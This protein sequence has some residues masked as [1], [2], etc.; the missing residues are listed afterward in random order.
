MYKVLTRQSKNSL[1]YVTSSLYS[2]TFCFVC[3][4]YLDLLADVGGPIGSGNIAL[5]AREEQKEA[6]KVQVLKQKISENASAIPVVLTRIKECMKRI[7]KL[8]PRNGI[9]HPAFN[10]KQT[11]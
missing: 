11:Y 7:D 5:L 4:C 6:E 8:Q 1:P 9:I 2:G 10:R 3:N